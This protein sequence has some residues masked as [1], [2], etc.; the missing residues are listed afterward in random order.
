LLSEIIATTDR[1]RTRKSLSAELAALGVAPGQLVMVH[2]SMRSLGFVVGG[3]VSLLDAMLD[4]LGPAGTL[5]MPAHS[6]DLS[7]PAGW[8]APPVPAAWVETVRAAMPPFDPSRTPTWGLGV[9]PELFRTWPGV[10]RSAHPTVSIA[11]HGPLAAEILGTHPLDDPHGEA[12]PL[13]RAYDRD[14]KLLLLGVSWHRA[15]LLHL[16]ERRAR[17]DAEATPA[18]APMLRDGRAVWQTYRDYDSDPERFGDVGDA[19]AGQLTIR[20]V[21]SARAIL[22]D[23]RT[24][25]DMGVKVLG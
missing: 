23:G 20:Q 24:A 17:P 7:D 6:G 22:A 11:A 16:A 8:S 3:A 13:A 1:P 9:V 5:M 15:T 25:V 14:V 10:L 18:G 12:S 4:V 21:G 2:V 19:L